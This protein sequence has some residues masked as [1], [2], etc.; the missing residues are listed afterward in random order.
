MEI[1]LVLSADYLP[2]KQIIKMAPLLDQLGYAQVSVPEIWGHDALSLLSI[3]AQNTRKVR[4]A[5]GIVNI[6]SRT[7]AVMA[8]TAASIDEVSRGRFVLGLGLSGPKVIENLHG[9]HFNKPIRRTREYVE[10]LRTLLAGKRLRYDSELLGN[11]TGFKISIR[12]IRPDIPIHIAALG[13][14]NISQTARI[15]DGWIPVIMPLPSFTQAVIDVKKEV[16]EG[17]DFAITPF[18]LTISGDEPHKMDLLRGHLAYYFGGMGSFYNNMLK[19]VGFEEEADTIS[20]LWK[21]GKI[22]EACAAVSDELLALTT[23]HGSQQEMEDQMI[24]II[25]AGATCPLVTVPFKTSVED[26]TDTVTK[27]ASLNN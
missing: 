16:P 13:P 12:D 17:K 23:V 10:V 24:A 8:M 1:G 15:A 19:R 7:P 27:I 14:K 4:L 25:K 18:V 26:A 21:R 9:M 5:T 2:S 20:D 11:M 3:L 22:S 6:F